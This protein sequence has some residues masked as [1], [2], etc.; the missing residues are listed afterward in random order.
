MNGF[1]GT[2]APVRSDLSLVLTILLGLAATVGAINAH[3]HRYSQHCP[4]MTTAALLNWVPV[5]AVMVPTG[6]AALTG[7]LDIEAGVP[8]GLVV[9]HAVVGLITQSTMTYTV[10]RM[11]WLEDLPPKKPI[12]LM[13]STITLWSVAI[14]TGV[15]VYVTLYV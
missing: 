1:L 3:R 11:N 7:A 5:L 9:A 6:V 8:T 4:V 13:R 10:T 14:I 15:A 2:Q 12:W